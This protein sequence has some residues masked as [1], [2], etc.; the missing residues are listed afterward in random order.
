MHSL[1][2]LP[3]FLAIDPHPAVPVHVNATT[4]CSHLFAPTMRTPRQ[5]D[6]L[7]LNSDRLDCI[8]VGA[9]SDRQQNHNCHSFKTC[10]EAFPLVEAAK[11]IDI[12]LQNS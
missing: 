3:I 7:S 12:D 6:S 4:T 1:T 8:G 2:S 9:W 11:K 10:F 5:I